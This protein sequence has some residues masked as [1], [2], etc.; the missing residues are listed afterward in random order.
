VLAL[1]FIPNVC[2]PRREPL[3]ALGFVIVSLGLA[4]T[5]FGFENVSRILSTRS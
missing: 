2:E 5:M 3:G 4:G 1:R